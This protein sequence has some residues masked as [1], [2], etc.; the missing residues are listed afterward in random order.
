MNVTNGKLI[1]LLVDDEPFDV[2]Y[3]QPARARARARPARGRPAPPCRVGSPAGAAVRVTSTRLVSF[4]QRSTAAILYEVEPLAGPVR[5]VVQ[6]ELVANEPSARR[7]SRDPRAAAGLESPLVSQEDSDHELRVVLV[8]STR[9]E[10]LALAAGM[11][12]IDRGAGRDGDRR[13]RARPTSAASRSRRTSRPGSG[14]G[15]SSSSP[16]AGRARRSMPALRDQVVAALAEARH[17]GW[18]G[19]LDGQRAYLDEFWG[20]ADV[21]LDGDT[22]LQQ[23]VRF[24]LFHTLQAGARASSGRSPPRA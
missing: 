4:V 15:S 22:E 13:P 1:R 9:S 5:V 3:G 14:S 21:E 19:L 7:S 23:A 24:A 11:D 17:T 10:R 8:H 12:H 2:R 20:G 18:D 16:T 6:S